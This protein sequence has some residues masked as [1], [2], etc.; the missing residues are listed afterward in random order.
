MTTRNR[1]TCLLLILLGP[2]CMAAGS[3]DQEMAAMVDGQV[4]L[5]SEILH[6]AIDSTWTV[7]AVLRRCG[8][9]EVLN[10]PLTHMEVLGGVRWL[11]DRVCQVK[12]QLSAEAV[13]D[14]LVA[15]VDASKDRPVEA[16]WLR[17]KLGAWKGTAFSAIGSNAS[18][19]PIAA[20]PAPTDVP[21]TAQAAPARLAAV[22][23]PDEPPQ[24]VFGL[25]DA[26]GVASSAGNP[27]KTA[28]L[29]EA[30]ALATLQDRI[31][32]LEVQQGVTLGSVAD[33]TP[34]ARLA[35]AQSVQQAR[36]Y[37]TEYRAD[38]SV[39]VRMSLNLRV[40]WGTLDAT[41]QTAPS[42]R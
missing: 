31:R 27:L 39:L 3:A 38:G 14:T 8:G 32:A 5:R 6:T 4:R 11:D 17:E 29:A 34:A 10:A 42:A 25:A 21:T 24:W 35:I 16:K 28:R 20:N 36:V 33:K 41:R 22:R 13:A 37:K 26:E 7:E 9:D 15:A 30:Q 40:L 1:T 2:L 18:A 19:L 23:L 12:V